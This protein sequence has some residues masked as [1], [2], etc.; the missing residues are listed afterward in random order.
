MFTLRLHALLLISLFV[1][2]AAGNASAATYHV[3]ASAEKAGNGT[4]KAPFRTIQKAVRVLKPGDTCWIHAGVYRETVKGIPSGTAQAPIRFCRFKND[5]VV[6]SGCNLVSGWKQ[7]KGKIHSTT[8]EMALKDGNQVFVDGNMV[9]EARWPNAGGVTPKYLLEFKQAVMGK[10]TTPERI[11][12]PS[13]PNRDWSGGS[14]WVSSHKRWYSWTGKIKGHGKGFLAIDNN[15]D[16]TGNHVCKP[17]GVFYV[18]GC[19]AALDAENEWWYDSATK[20]LHLWAPDGGKPSGRVEVKMRQ[21]AFDLSGTSHVMLK[22][23]TIFGATLLTDD[24][25]E[26]LQFDG[27]RMFYVHHSNRAERRYGSQSGSGVYLHGKGHSLRNSEIA[28]SSGNGLYLA[29]KGM[30]VI[31]NDIHDC[32]Y[33][34]TY[35][36]PL[37]FG[38]GGRSHLVSHN[39]IVRAG[40]SCV[41]TKGIHDSVLQFNDMGYAGYLTWDLGLTYANGVDGG[42]AEVRYNWLHDNLSPSHCM[43]L[44]FDHGCKNLI[45]HHNV[46]WNVKG[47]GLLNNQYANYLL[48][49]HNTVSDAEH[50]YASAWAAAQQQDL[51]GCHIKNNLATGGTKIRG[52]GLVQERNIWKA[53]GIRDK[54]FPTPMTGAIDAGKT[55]E[56]IT[57]QTKG[58]GP[59]VGAYE[60][61]GTQWKAGH[62]FKNPPTDI[63]AS[64]CKPAYR[65]LLTNP[66]WYVKDT[67]G[68]KLRGDCKTISTPHGQWTTDGLTM[69]GTCGIRMG[70]GE[71]SVEQTVTGLKP[72]TTYELMG[73]FRVEPGAKGCLM[74]R[75]NKEIAR[76]KP[77]ADTTPMPAPN[78][79]KR[80]RVAEARLKKRWQRCLL[81]FTTGPAE[82]KVTVIAKCLS[83]GTG[84]VYID[85]MGLQHVAR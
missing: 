35:C 3:S 36:A 83:G 82:T 1:A 25:S 72:K 13:I 44:Y 46:I 42:N 7:E 40:R 73:M 79:K 9:W 51:Y 61:G 23:L 45:L 54:K 68:W 41:G 77:V 58:K 4:E 16:T 19:R 37:C 52:S 34:G 48:Y 69:M 10:G 39:T 66:A 11:V 24:Q 12:A 6:I 59:D 81:R 50:G 85:D 20:R 21:V 74:I 56:G 30:Q 60:S 84:Y 29:G 62:D 78:A 64:R 32:N 5:K 33:M 38:G 80:N 43:G 14:V 75:Q 47:K 18:Y 28:Y 67:T 15:T 65:N 55:V 63:D 8:I 27:L 17:Q 22:G 76:S 57:H 49:Y 31:N 2:G 26:A 53:T 71:S 70:P